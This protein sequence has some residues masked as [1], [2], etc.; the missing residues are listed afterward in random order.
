MREI[1]L[2]CPSEQISSK[3]KSVLSLNG[4]SVFEHCTSASQA[5]SIANDVDNAIIICYKL[6]DIPPYVL[7]QMVPD[8][9]DIISFVHSGQGS[10]MSGSNLLVLNLPINPPDFV[11]SVQML[12][13]SSYAVYHSRSNSVNNR[14][15]DENAL[16]LKAKEY[17][18]DKYG[19]S[20]NAAHKILRK[21][22]MNEGRSLVKVASDVLGR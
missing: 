2:A 4:I 17:L 5:L 13:G 16:I 9:T 12:S 10:E 7:S 14:S 8:G 21:K 19:L 15:E 1:I 11:E 6:K 3:I 18:M 22:S 20:E